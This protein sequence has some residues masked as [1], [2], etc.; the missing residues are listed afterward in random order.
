MN[1]KCKK[2]NSHSLSVNCHTFEYVPRYMGHYDN[3]Y[4]ISKAITH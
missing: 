4:Y 1:K 2:K 3:V